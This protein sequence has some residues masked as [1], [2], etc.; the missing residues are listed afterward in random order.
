MARQAATEPREAQRLGRWA[1]SVFGVLIALMVL[2]MGGWYARQFLGQ[3]GG[4]AKN[5]GSSALA[6]A[7]T[8]VADPPA[9]LMEAV[10]RRTRQWKGE[11]NAPVTIVEFGDFQ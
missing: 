11:A 1:W 5:A 9:S 10:V 8:R 7:G 3:S 4:L 6:G 2:G